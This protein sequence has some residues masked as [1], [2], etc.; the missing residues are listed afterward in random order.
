MDDNRIL[1]SYRAALEMYNDEGRAVWGRFNN[2]LVAH[3]IIILVISSLISDYKEDNLGWLIICLLFIG[4]LLCLV[5]GMVMLH[6][7]ATLKAWNIIVKRIEIDDK[8]P[9]IVCTIDRLRICGILNYKW[10]VSFT[11]FLFLL[12][13]VC[14]S[15]TTDYVILF[16]VFAFFE[17]LFLFI[18]Y[19][20][21]KRSIDVFDRQYDGESLV[22]KLIRI[23]EDLKVNQEDAI[24]KIDRLIESVQKKRKLII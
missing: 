21:T 9:N 15:K 24:K 14:M 12:V 11:I 13:F 3:S 10:L 7:L 8:V 2:Y 20:C 1:E 16:C 6:G 23:R 19:I 18:L 17:I 4:M 5:W 22:E